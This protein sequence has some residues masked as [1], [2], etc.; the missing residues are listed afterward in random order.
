MYCGAAVLACCCTSNC[1]TVGQIEKFDE[2][3]RRYRMELRMVREMRDYN[4]DLMT[5]AESG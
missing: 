1:L 2:F 4:D 5:A 3:R